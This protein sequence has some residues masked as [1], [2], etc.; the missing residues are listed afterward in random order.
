MQSFT[1]I[2]TSKLGQS[3][4]HDF[5]FFDITVTV[6]SGFKVMVPLA[7]I[8]DNTPFLEDFFLLIRRKLCL[9]L[10][11][12][13]LIMPVQCSHFHVTSSRRGSPPHWTWTP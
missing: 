7:R 12:I 9:A 13:F 10:G 8:F 4:E 3:L 11:G 5:K 6:E 2:G 1:G